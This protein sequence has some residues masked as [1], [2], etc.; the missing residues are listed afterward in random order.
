[1][2]FPRSLEAWGSVAFNEIFLEEV[3]ENEGRLP[4]DD[5]CTGGGWPEYPEFEM[6]EATENEREILVTVNVYFSEVVPGSCPDLPWREDRRGLFAL[7]IDKRTGEVEAT[8]EH[9]ADRP[10][11]EYY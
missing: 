1:M 2:E 3:Y 5:F 11:L 9:D 8:A 6:R 4:I 7:R 10:N